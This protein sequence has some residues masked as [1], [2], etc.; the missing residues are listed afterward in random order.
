MKKFAASLFAVFALLVLAGCCCK[1]PNLYSTKK[2]KQI[3]PAEA[4]ASI[5]G[6]W[7]LKDDKGKAT[8]VTMTF[9]KDGSMIT[10]LPPKGEKRKGSWKLE[11]DNLVLYSGKTP[12]VKLSGAGD[13]NDSMYFIWRGGKYAKQP[14]T[15][16]LIQE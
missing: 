2:L 9:A 7:S 1:A 3:P 12:T 4:R 6:T 13:G 5:I 15:I 8:G 16:F 11:G 10:T 14:L